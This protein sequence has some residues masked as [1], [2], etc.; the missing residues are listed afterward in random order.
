MQVK[1]V[2]Q[3]GPLKIGFGWLS[4]PQARRLRN[5]SGSRPQENIP[6][7]SFVALARAVI[8]YF[9]LEQKRYK[10]IPIEQQ[11]EVITL[12]G[13]VVGNEKNEP[14]LRAHTVLRLSYRTT[15]GKHFLKGYVR[16]IASDHYGSAWD[17]SFGVNGPISALP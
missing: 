16:H 5:P 4:S 1:E 14:A 12:G 10:P 9:E 13:D 3:K 2:S 6:A 15:R 8:A 11:I 17:I 7:A